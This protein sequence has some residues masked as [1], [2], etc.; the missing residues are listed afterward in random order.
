L[1]DTPQLDCVIDGYGGFAVE[2]RILM[3]F[4]CVVWL[5]WALSGEDKPYIRSRQ[6]FVAEQI[7]SK[8]LNYLKSK[9]IVL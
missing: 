7:V 9:G 4:F 8:G 2:D 1:F 6:L 5:T 3:E